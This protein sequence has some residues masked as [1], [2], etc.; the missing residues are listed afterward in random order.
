MADALAFTDVPKTADPGT[1]FAVSVEVLADDERV[2]P[3]SP[4]ELSAT[5]K[6][7]ATGTLTCTDLS[8]VAKDGVASFAGCKVD[9]GGTYTLTATLGTLIA[10]SEIVV[11]GPAVLDFVTEPSG[12]A[13][14]TTWAT[15]PSLV[16]ADAA[17]RGSYS[18]P[19]RRLRSDHQARARAPPAPR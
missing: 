17:R 15:Q 6:D 18:T 14:G 13:A 3:T 4:V 1:S 12:G 7:G 8:V 9:K 19:S 10:T 16:V 2:T 11:S 5:A